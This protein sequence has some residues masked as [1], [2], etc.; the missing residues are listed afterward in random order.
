MTLYRVL[1]NVCGQRQYAYVNADGSLNGLTS[2]PDKA[3]RLSKVDAMRL[4]RQV[5]R[6]MAPNADIEA[7]P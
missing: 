4:L 5:R 7:V 1:A 6:R 3:A 2:R